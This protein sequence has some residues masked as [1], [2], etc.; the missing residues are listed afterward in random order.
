LSTTL[1]LPLPLTVR[2]SLSFRS[3]PIFRTCTLKPSVRSWRP[4]MQGIFR[5]L[6]R[7]ST[8]G[9][10]QG[11]LRAAQIRAL[12]A[13]PIGVVLRTSAPTSEVMTSRMPAYSG[14]AAP[15]SRAGSEP[16]CRLRPLVLH[17]M[18]PDGKGTAGH[19]S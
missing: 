8:A 10:L 15:A 19:P 7:S 5:A 2:R 17:G 9:L 16:G 4:T 6:A 12:I 11:M 13:P 14:V 3:T 18:A 1:A